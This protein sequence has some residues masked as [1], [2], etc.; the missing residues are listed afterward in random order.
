MSEIRDDADA[1][2]W[3]YLDHQRDIETWA[4]LR[5]EGSELVH[6][7]LLA[8]AP[9]VEELAAELGAEPYDADL[10]RGERPRVGMRRVS[11]P[12]R[13]AGLVAVV[14]E[15]RPDSLL[16]IGRGDPWPY[17][18]V[19]DDGAQAD[20]THMRGLTAAFSPLRSQLG[21]QTHTW[22]AFWSYVEP[23]EGPG[24]D[25]AALARDCVVRLR[26]LWVR[27][28]PVVDEFYAGSHP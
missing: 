5:E 8:L 11:W 20:P 28:A 2:A 22:W 9:A 25:P 23:V 27:S 3:F 19:R 16:G 6:R 13:D 4:D 26:D 14:I 12:R 18:A 17:V 10:D 21:G 15:W 24:I 7:H 1:R